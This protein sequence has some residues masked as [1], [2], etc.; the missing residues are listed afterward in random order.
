LKDIVSAY[1]RYDGA[2]L[3]TMTHREKPWLEARGN[4]DESEGSNELI[5]KQSL[6]DYFALKLKADG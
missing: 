2:A 6:R 3:S 4:L 5:T 1:G